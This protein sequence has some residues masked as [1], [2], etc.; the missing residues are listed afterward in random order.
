[1]NYLPFS[2]RFFCEIFSLF[3]RLI[4]C[5]KCSYSLQFY[6]DMLVKFNQSNKF[7]SKFKKNCK[8]LPDNSRSNGSLTIKNDKDVSNASYKSSKL[9]RGKRLRANSNGDATVRCKYLIS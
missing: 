7:N 9:G 6:Y 1:M 3:A 5:N 4:V 8:V 2:T